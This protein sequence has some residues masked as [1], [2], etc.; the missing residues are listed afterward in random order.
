MYWDLRADGPVRW[1]SAKD[2]NKG[3]KIGRSG[4]S[5]RVHANHDGCRTIQLAKDH[6][7]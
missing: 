1:E 3:P 7:R 6:G 2:F 5:R 4:S